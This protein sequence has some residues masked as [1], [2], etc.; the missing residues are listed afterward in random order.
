MHFNYYLPNRDNVTLPELLSLGLGYVFEPD[1]A[2]SPAAS[3]APR[4][5]ING[6]DDQHGLIVSRSDTHC[7]YYKNDQVWKKSIS[8]DY[9]VGMWKADRPTPQSLARANVIPGKDILLDDG[10]TWEIPRARQFEEIDDDIVALNA[11]PTNLTLD[12]LG[13]WCRGEVKKRYRKLWQLVADYFT[14]VADAAVNEQGE[15]RI[16]FAYESNVAIEAF[17]CNYRVSAIE[18][19]LLGIYDTD[20]HKQVIW[21]VTDRDGWELLYKKK[22]ATQDTGSSTNGLAVHQMAAE[23]DTHQQSPT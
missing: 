11:L 20:V 17:T 19:D 4:Q 15:M 3:F 6:P 18:L 7:G 22:L 5:V 2:A 14:M 23:A 16:T 13:Q 9:W 8:G 12:G 21:I 10:N 1:S